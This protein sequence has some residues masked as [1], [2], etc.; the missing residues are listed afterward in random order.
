[1]DDS[2]GVSETSQNVMYKKSSFHSLPVSKAVFSVNVPVSVRDITT[3]LV[4]EA[5]HS[6]T[7]LVSLH[8]LIFTALFNT[9]ANP[10]GQVTKMS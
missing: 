2:S 9:E 7:M 10:V 6:E 5:R 4:S 8:P 3:H 1:M